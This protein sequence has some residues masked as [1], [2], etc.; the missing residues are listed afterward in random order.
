MDPKSCGVCKEPLVPIKHLQLSSLRFCAWGFS[1]RLAI[2]A[3]GLC[4]PATM[5]QTQYMGMARSNTY[6]LGSKRE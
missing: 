3:L 6:I 4:S 2:K 1:L 5:N